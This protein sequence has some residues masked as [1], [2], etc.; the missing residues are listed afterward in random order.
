[1]NPSASLLPQTVRAAVFRGVDAPLAVETIT[2]DPPQATEVLVRMKVVGLCHT[3]QHVLRGQLQLG[4]T[5]IVLGHE[6]SGVVEAVGAEVHHVAVGDH[7]ALLWNPACG[8]CKPCLHG[9][10]HRC[11]RGG[12]RQINMGP[13]LNGTYRRWDASGA[14]V[15]AACM[16]GAFAEKTVVDQASIIVVDRN[17]PFDAVA[18][19]ACGVTGG[20]GAAVHA[21]QVRPG[22][23]VL[24]IGAGGSGMSA[25]QAARLAGA[26]RVIAADRHAWK[27]KA[28]LDFG[29]SDTVLVTTDGE[30]AGKVMQ[31]TEGQGVDHGIVCAGSVDALVQAY[32]ATSVGGAVVLSGIMPPCEHIPFM[33]I[34]VLAGNGKTLV[35]SSY[36]GSSPL[37]GIP[38]VLRHYRHG[39][40]KIQEL[41]S[42]SYSLDEVASAYEDLA[43]GRNLRGVIRF[44]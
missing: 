39:R 29:A 37:T 44:D 41:I 24:V 2:L 25:I 38:E 6:G 42:R 23:S 5:P 34:E 43:A 28:A 32:R 7:V 22:D 4:M 30:L 15:G 40:L 18:L 3:E 16:L 12:G 26:A 20:F 1:M 13:Q 36:G 21:T 31:L 33:P 19:S 10:H 35:G 14:K 9:L 8:Q 17:L 27:L 11:V